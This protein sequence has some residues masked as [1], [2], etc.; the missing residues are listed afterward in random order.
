LTGT[1]LGPFGDG[2]LDALIL[3]RNEREAAAPLEPLL[4]AFAPKTLAR[5]RQ[6][7]DEAQ[8]LNEMPVSIGQVTIGYAL[9]YLVCGFAPRQPD[10]Y[11]DAG[12][13][14]SS[15]PA[16]PGD[17]RWPLR[18][19]NAVYAGHSVVVSEWSWRA[20]ASMS[21]IQTLRPQVLKY[22]F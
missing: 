21:A 13:R 20:L 12:T 1:A 2:L 11:T 5:L 15:R 4:A 10:R 17:G 22:S 14:S 18:L 16:G 9:V 6:L 3:W 19:A 7:D 8:A